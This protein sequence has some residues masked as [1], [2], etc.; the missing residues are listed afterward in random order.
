MTGL[1]RYLLPMMLLT[2]P[3]AAAVQGCAPKDSAS[4][5]A[6]A[7]GPTASTEKPPTQA[8][9]SGFSAFTFPHRPP[10]EW[11]R[12]AMSAVGT[13][14]DNNLVPLA[15]G[16]RIPQP[17][18]LPAH[19]FFGIPTDHAR[20]IVYICDRSGSMTDSIDYV[21]QELRCSI[22]DLDKDQQFQVLFMST[23]APPE[24]TPKSLQPATDKNKELAFEFIDGMVA[25]GETAPD[26][27]LIRAFELKPDVIILLTDG[28]FDKS[29]ADLAKRL[30]VGRKIP[31]S[32]I[33]FLYRGPDIQA[34]TSVL[35]RIATDSG[36]EYKFISEADLVSLEGTWA[37]MVQPGEL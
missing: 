2:L 1:W 17:D 28:E 9:D 12:A 20:S 23:G 3:A 33:C 30:N 37:R 27:A 14:R 25:P 29:V 8:T 7:S 18:A 15:P 13:P 31:I 19:G 16:S 4:P 10:S 36:G 11:E 21:K 32:T 5:D 34:G 24:M 35:E 22:A 6:A 26:G